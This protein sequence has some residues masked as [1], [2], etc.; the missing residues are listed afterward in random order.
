[1]KSQLN[2]ENTYDLHNKDN[3]NKTL[4]IS[5]NDV[6]N[7]YSIKFTKLPSSC[8]TAINNPPMILNIFMFIILVDIHPDTIPSLPKIL[9]IPV[10]VNPAPTT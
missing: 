8:V 5:L 9:M 4:D 6:I 2:P 3:F 7:K 1:M 10:D